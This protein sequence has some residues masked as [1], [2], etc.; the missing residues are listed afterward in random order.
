MWCHN[1]HTVNVIYIWVIHLLIRVFSTI[2]PFFSERYYRWKILL[3]QAFQ[4]SLWCQILSCVYY[5]NVLLQWSYKRKLILRYEAYCIQGY[6]RQV[7]ISPFSTYKQFRPI[8]NSSRQSLDLK[9]LFEPIQ[10][11]QSSICS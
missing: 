1:N 3:W 9:I 4:T 6:L 8:L 10:C 11:T 2:K 7:L 5:V